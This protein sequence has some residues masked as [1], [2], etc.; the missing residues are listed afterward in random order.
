[1]RFFILLLT[2][3]VGIQACQQ[4]T[5]SEQTFANEKPTEDWTLLPFQ[6]VDS[7]NPCLLPSDER[8]FMC[9]VRG[10]EVLW[11]VKDVFNPA[12]V[13]KDSL[14][15][16]IYRAED[17]VGI[18]NGTS[19]IGLAISED[20]Y[21]FSKLEEPVLYPDEDFMKKYEWEGGIEDPRVVE[22]EEGTYIMTYTAYD[23]ETARLCVASSPDLKQWTKHGL[24]FAEAYE[25]KYQDVWGKSGA[26][27]CQQQGSQLIAR[28]VN[29]RYWMYWGD[30]Y[31]YAATSDD[32]IHWQP[33]EE[34]DTL[35]I[36]MSYR[37]G[38]FDS[39]L[40]EPGPPAMLIDGGIRL[41]YNGRNYGET[42]D[43]NIEEGTYRAGQAL[44]DKDDPAK[45][46][47]RLEEDFFRPDK[48]YEIFGQVNKVV[49]LEGLVPF[50]KKWL[51]YYGTADSKIAV[52]E[53]RP[54]TTAQ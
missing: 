34:K 7:V 25:G 5:A 51:L 2:A 46:I 18:Y 10:E 29:G 11:E 23:G 41:I 31:M 49:F 17:S 21:H 24:A 45:L 26:I 22:T 4:Q 53:Y 13:V 38:Y 30:K 35:K 16:M 3:A 6:K 32:L 47:D 42:R 12:V 9:P 15:Y 44:F 28:K 52:A 33:L 37:P 14:V 43:M 48:D 20:G 50:N 19:R 54:D 40:V 1:M 8:S 39:D 27:V 36:V